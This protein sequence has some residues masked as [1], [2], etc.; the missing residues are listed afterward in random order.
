MF[1]NSCSGMDVGQEKIVTTFKNNISL[2]DNGVSGSGRI[3]RLNVNKSNELNNKIITLR[4]ESMGTYQEGLI[5][6]FP[7]PN[8]DLQSYL[9]SA[10]VYYNFELNSEFSTESIKANFDRILKNEGKNY[11]VILSNAS[12]LISA[13]FYPYRNG[14]KVLIEAKLFS[15]KTT[16]NIINVSQSIFELEQRLKNIVNS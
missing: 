12:C 11:K 4:A 15:I 16:N 3:Y 8:F 7:L 14:S 13:R 6:P 2:V 9:I 5:L 10:S 1:E